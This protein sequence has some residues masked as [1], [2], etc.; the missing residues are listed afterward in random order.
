ML[1]GDFSGHIVLWGCNDNDPRGEL[2]EDFITKNDICL[3]NDKSNTYL[4]SGKGTFSSLD[5]SLCHPSLYLDYDWSVC[6]D[7]RGSDHF[8]ILIESVQTHD[9]AHNP[10]WKLNKAD[11]D[12]FHTLCNESLTDTF[13]SDSSDP[14]TDFTSSLINISE[15]CIPKTSTNPKKSNPWYN[16]DCK[17]AIKQ[18]KDT[19]SKFCKFPTHENLNTYRNSRAKARRTIKSAKRKSWRTYVSNL[20]YKTPT[21]K[22]WDMV[23]KISGKSK[24]A[25]YH[26]LNYNF[27]NANE[28][29]STNQ[30]IADTLASQCSNSST[31]HYS[32]EFQKYKKE[33]EKTKLNF[34]SSDNEEYNTPFNLDELKDAISKA[35]DT[36]T[37][38]DEV[39]YQMLKHLPPKSL[40]A[41]LDIFND[42]WETG[43]FPESWELATIIPIPKPG[44]DHAEPNSYRPIALTSCLCKTLERMINV[45]LV[46]YLESNNLISPVQSGFRSE[47][48]TNDNLVRLETVIRDAFVAKEHVV[49]VF[50]D[51]EKA[52][53]TTWRHGIM[54]DLHDLGIRGR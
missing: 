10:K 36:A 14:I 54:R 44:K 52:Y 22:V 23:R 33:Q 13:L 8:P 32:E 1:V 28:T 7:Q 19:L 9:E 27:N 50:F 31:S 20:N 26:N 12:L 38:P 18:R 4:D 46:W 43:K 47:R 30:D 3:M 5:L 35:H 39:H 16:D 24:S 45:R 2:I 34:K 48:S 51:L 11:W 29:A 53:D 17:E 49:A 41:L 21:K 15:K 37:G 6:K 25:S 40:Q 42:M